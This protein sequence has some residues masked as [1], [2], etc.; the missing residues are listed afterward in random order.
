MTDPAPGHDEL[1]QRTAKRLGMPSVQVERV[2]DTYADE[3]ILTERKLRLAIESRVGTRETAVTT[4]FAVPT[5]ADGSPLPTPEAAV[6]PA[7]KESTPRKRS[8]KVTEAAKPSDED[9]TS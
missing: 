6:K 4:E 2:I 8:G 9:T 3:Y 7:K 5:L 1:I